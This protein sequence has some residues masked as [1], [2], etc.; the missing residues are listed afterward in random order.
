M[1]RALEID[2]MSPN[3]LADMGQMHYFAREYEEAES[4]CRK[5]LE[6]NPDFSFAHQYLTFIYVVKGENDKAFEEKLKAD[7]AFSPPPPTS[8][9]RRL[10][11]AIRQRTERVTA[12]PASRGC[13]SSILK[14]SMEKAMGFL[15]M[16]F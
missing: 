9:R 12:S 6:I 8:R 4:Y 5:A 2:P 1:R 3:F 13:G 11:R 14:Q 16:R 15:T 10:S 7:R